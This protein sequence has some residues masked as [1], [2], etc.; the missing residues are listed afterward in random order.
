MICAAK[1]LTPALHNTFLQCA[2]RHRGKPELC[3]GDFQNMWNGVLAV[4][5]RDENN[6]KKQSMSDME[7]ETLLDCKVR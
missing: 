4:V 1:E 5:S 6:A 3:E 7:E 2:T